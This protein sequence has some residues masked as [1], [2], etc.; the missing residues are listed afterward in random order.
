VAVSQALIDLAPLRSSPQV[1]RLWIGRGFSSLG[2][3]MTLVAVMFQVW[4]LRHSTIWT[5]G[6][7]LAPRHCRCSR[8][9]S[10]PA[11]SSTAA[12]AKARDAAC[13]DCC[14]LASARLE[15]VGPGW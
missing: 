6:V 9:A 8:S 2:S 5:G 4:R 1:R 11:R 12:T 3:K 14:E 13:S 7:G 15:A 10:P